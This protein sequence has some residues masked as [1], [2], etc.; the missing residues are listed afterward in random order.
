MCRPL[1]AAVLIVLMVLVVPRGFASDDDD[2]AEP[3]PRF[4]AKTLEGE[5]FDNTSI[6]GKVV[7]LDFWTTWCKYCRQEEEMVDDLKKSFPIKALIMV[8]V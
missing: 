5:Q 3:A 6:K 7:L 1:S 8:W 4:H 2:N